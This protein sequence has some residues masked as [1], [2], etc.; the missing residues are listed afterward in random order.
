VKHGKYGSQVFQTFAIH[1]P[2]RNRESNKE[3]FA[4]QIQ[5]GTLLT[6]MMRDAHKKMISRETFA[7]VQG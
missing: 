2:R 3:S 1:S 5:R 7:A 4:I 6:A